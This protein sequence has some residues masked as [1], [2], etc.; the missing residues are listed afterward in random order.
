MSEK[1]NKIHLGGTSTNISKCV[2]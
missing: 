1:D 2:G